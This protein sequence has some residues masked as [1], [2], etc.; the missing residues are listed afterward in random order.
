MVASASGQA[1]FHLGKRN[2]EAAKLLSQTVDVFEGSVV[3]GGLEGVS[4]GGGVGGGASVGGVGLGDGREAF[5][6]FTVFLL[7]SLLSSSSCWARFH[8]PTCYR[9]LQ[10]RF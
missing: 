4:V 2:A 9:R 10:I 3:V 7:A 1:S 6:R 8:L 5:F